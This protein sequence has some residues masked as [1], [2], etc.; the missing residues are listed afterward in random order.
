MFLPLAPLLLPP[1]AGEDAAQRQMGA[2]L[3]VDLLP[4]QPERS[5]TRTAR[6]Q[7]HPKVVAELALFDQAKPE[8]PGQRG[9]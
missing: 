1:L 5:F 9:R 6:P 3:D 2:A 7:Q 8:S 4:Q